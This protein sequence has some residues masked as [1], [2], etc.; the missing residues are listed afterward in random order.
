MSGWLFSL[1]RSL[2]GCYYNTRKGKALPGKR[3]EPLKKDIEVIAELCQGSRRLLLYMIAD[4]KEQHDNPDN[5]C[6]ERNELR[7]SQ[8]HV[9]TPS[10]R[11][12]GIKRSPL[13]FA[14]K[15]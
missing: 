9:T 6:A 10:E 7:G 1:D 14:G 2:C 15:R 4:Y 11:L 5:K 3:S 13:V 12:R 8:L